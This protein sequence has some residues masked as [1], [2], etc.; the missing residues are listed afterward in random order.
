MG[1]V[2]LRRQQST[3]LALSASS[4][5]PGHRL[6]QGLPTDLHPHGGSDSKRFSKLY[7]EDLYD[8]DDDYANGGKL[9]TFSG[10]AHWASG[11]TPLWQ[12]QHGA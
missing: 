7:S 1:I 11:W 9:F 10:G 3:I 12:L 8:Y 5:A 4:A 2:R 6:A